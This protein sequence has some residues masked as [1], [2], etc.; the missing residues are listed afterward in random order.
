MKKLITLITL[1][2]LTIGCEP[3]VV[4]ID[5]IDT[6][7]ILDTEDLEDTGETPSGFDAFIGDYSELVCD[8]LVECELVEDFRS[9]PDYFNEDM[10]D[11]GFECE[12]FNSTAAS[13]CIMLW[14][15]ITCEQL[16]NL[17]MIIPCHE[18]CSNN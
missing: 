7:K 8:K 3:A 15:G 17:V 6:G 10:D 1:S 12:D 13:E 9:C 2:M 11:Y 18:V 14:T 5:T 4:D 16:D